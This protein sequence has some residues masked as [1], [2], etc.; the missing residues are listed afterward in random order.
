MYQVSSIYLILIFLPGLSTADQV[1]D[2]SGRG[3]GMDVVKSNIEK[4]GGKIEIESIIGLG[5]T[6]K[7]KLPLPLAIIPSLVVTVCKER[8]AIP[9]V[10][11]V[12]LI[13]IPAAQVHKK[14]EIIGNQ[15]V[16]KRLNIVWKNLNYNL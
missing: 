6:F 1:T 3:V 9:Q 16:M 15:E 5:S 10:N 14:I 2:L 11:V 7:I 4:I 12:E 8:Y 13:R